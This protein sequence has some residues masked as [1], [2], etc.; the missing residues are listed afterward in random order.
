MREFAGRQ[1]IPPGQHS[2]CGWMSCPCW[3]LPLVFD[4][5]DLRNLFRSMVEF[6]NR[7]AVRISTPLQLGSFP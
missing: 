3:S 6:E 1:A 7:K 4:D 5:S 2:G